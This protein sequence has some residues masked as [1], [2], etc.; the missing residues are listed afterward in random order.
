MYLGSWAFL[1]PSRAHTTGGFQALRA[2]IHH[3]WDAPEQRA[4]TIHAKA[5]AKAFWVNYGC[6]DHIMKDGHSMLRREYIVGPTKVFEK[7]SC[8]L[9]L[10][11]MLAGAPVA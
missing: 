7:G 6:Q 10:P 11:E 3:F 9:G 5:K 4:R 1:P 8:P 2:G